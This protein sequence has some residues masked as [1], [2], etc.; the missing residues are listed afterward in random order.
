MRP[1]CRNIQ[2]NDLYY[3]NGG[4][5]FENIRTGKKGEVSDEL[6][7]KVFRFHPALSNIINENPVVADMI[8]RLNLKLESNEL[9]GVQ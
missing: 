8:K 4:N 7:A 6:A 3:F 2:N 1:I 9:V 5:E